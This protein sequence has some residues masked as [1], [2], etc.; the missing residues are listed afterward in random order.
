MSQQDKQ[1]NRSK[2]DERDK[3]GQHARQE[4]TQQTINNTSKKVNKERSKND[5]DEKVKDKVTGANQDAP[6]Y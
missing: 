5:T 3:H 1:K 6:P 2:P 4:N